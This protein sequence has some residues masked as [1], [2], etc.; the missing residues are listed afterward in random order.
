MTGINI[1]QKLAWSKKSVLTT[2]ADCNFLVR[3]S[4]L[5]SS[6]TVTLRGCTSLL[7]PHFVFICDLL[8]NRNLTTRFPLKRNYSCKL[9]F[10]LTMTT[11]TSASFASQWLLRTVVIWW[12]GLKCQLEIHF[13]LWFTKLRTTSVFSKSTGQLFPL[14]EV[15]VLLV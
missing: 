8:L 3:V 11:V 15:C 2:G 12:Y 9:R 6:M 1:I 13:I 14:A 10:D 4:I 7:L 5:S